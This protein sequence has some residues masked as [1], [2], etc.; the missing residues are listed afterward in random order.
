MVVRRRTTSTVTPAS[1]F[2]IECIL[3]ST[4]YRSDSLG[5]FDRL[6]TVDTSDY[7]VWKG[8]FGS[9]TNLAA[10][11]NRNGV[12]DAADYVVWR[13]SRGASSQSVPA[14]HGENATV[15]QA[16]QLLMAVPQHRTS[17]PKRSPFLTTNSAE[18]LRERSGLLQTAHLDEFFAELGESGA[19]RARV[20]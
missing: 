3:D 2:S 4:K 15:D 19:L 17:V 9:I 5:D 12:V 16:G 20:L 8:A 10:D 1:R 7:N 6:G 11:G 13:N 18:S 14:G